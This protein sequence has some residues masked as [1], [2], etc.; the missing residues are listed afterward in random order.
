METESQMASRAALPG[1]CLRTVFTEVRGHAVNKRS[2]WQPLSSVLASCGTERGGWEAWRGLRSRAGE[3]A[4]LE[5]AQAH[6]LQLLAVPLP[7]HT[8]SSTLLLLMACNR[9][10]A[11]RW[12]A[13]AH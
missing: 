7:G 13:K 5:C 2:P 3:P 4:P 11:P 8:S 10:S 1:R 6:L 9:P 12:I